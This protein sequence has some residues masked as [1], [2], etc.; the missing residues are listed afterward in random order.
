MVATAAPPRPR[1]AAP[2][3]GWRARRRTPRRTR[4]A[5]A[6]A[7]RHLVRAERCAS[8]R[9][10]RTPLASVESPTEQTLFARTARVTIGPMVD[11]GPFLH[12][13]V[14]G[15]GVYRALAE[16]GVP[17]HACRGPGAQQDDRVIIGAGDD[18]GV[19]RPERQLGKEVRPDRDEHRLTRPGFL[20]DLR[21]RRNED[22]PRAEGIAAALSR[23][24]RKHRTQGHDDRPGAQRTETDHCE[25]KAVR[26]SHLHTVT[27]AH[28]MGEQSAGY[29]GAEF[30]EF[31]KGQAPVAALYRHL[32][33]VSLDPFFQGRNEVA[34][35]SSFRPEARQVPAQSS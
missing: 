1:R 28:S 19:V 34:H 8:H 20:G 26:Q 10:R 16:H 29:P 2:S 27:G 23:E 14:Q 3:P 15:P 7:H 31:G 4:A 25:G 21:V 33:R 35:V 30:V 5:L 9:V 24:R 22:Q 17:G 11:Q 32:M 6:D 18:G 13:D 12:S